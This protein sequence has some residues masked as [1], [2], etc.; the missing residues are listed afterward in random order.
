M[1]TAGTEITDCNH[2]REWFEQVGTILTFVFT[3]SLLTLSRVD[4]CP[5]RRV[6]P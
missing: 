3:T 1:R 2:E 5:G 4:Y 6:C